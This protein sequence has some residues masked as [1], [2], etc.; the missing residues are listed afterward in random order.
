[1]DASNRAFV[2]LVTAY[3]QVLVVGVKDAEEAMM[4]AEQKSDFGDF[5]LDESQIHKTLKPEAVAEERQALGL[6]VIDWT[7]K[8]KGQA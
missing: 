1:M 8:E 7:S 6:N 3:R 5:V 2:V 4:A